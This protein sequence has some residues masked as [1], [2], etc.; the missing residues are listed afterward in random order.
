MTSDTPTPA[1]SA[2]WYPNP[3]KPGTQRYWDGAAWT[4]HVAPVGPAK[5]GPNVGVIVAIIAGGLVAF[6]AALAALA[7]PAYTQQ[8]GKDAERAAKLDVSTLGREIATYYVTGDGPTPEITQTATSYHLVFAN[9]EQLD[10]PRSQDVDFVAVKGGA[11]DWCVAVAT[12]GDD[13][14]FFEYSATH[15]QVMG[16]C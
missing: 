11:T 10:V 16:S 9:G 14:R 5:K 8:Q 2:G 13:R 1:A 3:E 15:G 6:F 7:I 12:S 4:D